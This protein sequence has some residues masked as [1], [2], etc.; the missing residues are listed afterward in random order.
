MPQK[1]Q[2]APKRNRTG[3]MPRINTRITTAQQTYLKA[4][5]KRDNITEGETF[6]EIMDYY[7]KKH[8]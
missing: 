1:K 2:E 7:I 4:K 8:K 6:R 3:A 5:A